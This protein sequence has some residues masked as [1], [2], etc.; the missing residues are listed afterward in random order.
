[1]RHLLRVSI[2]AAG[3]VAVCLP[4]ASMAQPALGY[5]GPPRPVYHRPYH[6]HRHLPLRRPPPH[7]DFGPR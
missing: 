1:M 4:A 6:H 3:L 7:R 2:M 5:R